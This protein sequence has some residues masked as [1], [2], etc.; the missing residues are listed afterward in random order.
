MEIEGRRRIFIQALLK[1]MQVSPTRMVT[2]VQSVFQLLEGMVSLTKPTKKSKLLQKIIFIVKQKKE[3]TPIKGFIK[4]EA[5]K[6]G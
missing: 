1:E 6:K 5:Y 3:A 4:I 2:D